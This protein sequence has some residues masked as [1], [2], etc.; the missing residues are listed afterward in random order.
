[1]RRLALGPGAALITLAMLSAGCFDTRGGDD[2]VASDSGDDDHDDDE[3]DDD[4]LDPD[5]EPDL[6]FDP[7]Y[8]DIGACTVDCEKTVTF[9]IVNGGSAPLDLH[10]HSF[11]AS[12][13]SGMALVDDADLLAMQQ[14]GT[15]LQP[16]ESVTAAIL[17]TPRDVESYEGSLAVQSNDPDQPMATATFIG[18]GVGAAWYADSFVQEH[19]NTCDILWVVD[20]SGSMADNQENIVQD[21]ESFP[22]LLDDAGVDY[23]LACA[24]ASGPEFRGQTPVVDNATV[25]G[26]ALF[27]DNCLVGTGGAAGDGLQ[28]GYLSL[29]MSAAEVPPNDGF[30]REEA[31]LM[32]VFVTDDGDDGGTWAYWVSAYQSLRADPDRVVLNAI[33]GTDGINAV[34]CNDNGGSALR[35]TG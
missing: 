35:G 28:N 26:P 11:Q 29:S 6:Q 3:Y 4:D 12:P 14:S 34:D 22:Q 19:W 24:A 10:G 1:M 2:P 23:R 15:P 20:D 25:S 21:L 16:G 9:A 30:H 17:F 8:H 13:A 33:C 27:A 32:V 18:M 5:A 7:A 31:R